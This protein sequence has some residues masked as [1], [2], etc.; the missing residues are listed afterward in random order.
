MAE[1][2]LGQNEINVTRKAAANQAHQCCAQPGSVL[3][4]LVGRG[5]ANLYLDVCDICVDVMR[6]WAH[7]TPP[8]CSH[9]DPQYQLSWLRFG[10]EVCL[11]SCYCP[12]NQEICDVEHAQR[13]DWCQESSG[14][15]R[16]IG[17]RPEEGVPSLN[18]VSS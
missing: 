13:L 12:N 15:S 2:K 7:L 3:V 4:D 6:R 18:L 16:M 5:V 1:K 14:E 17:P 11:L 10:H 9:T 8:H